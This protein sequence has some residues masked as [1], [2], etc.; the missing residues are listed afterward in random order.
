MTEFVSD[1]AQLR[2]GPRYSL[3]S[4]SST[5]S[6]HGSFQSVDMLNLGPTSRPSSG[7][8]NPHSQRLPLP[9]PEFK[10]PSYGYSYGSNPSPTSHVQSGYGDFSGH[11][12]SRATTPGM[13]AHLPSISLHSQKRAY[14]Q[15]RKDPS[16]DA[17]RE[18]KVK[19][20][21]VPPW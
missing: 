21:S 11:P 6:Y 8:D 5:P 12:G 18:R 13:S 19:V 1:S 15:R 17:C 3:S 7:P 14:R 9:P 4:S 2:C 10:S 16:C 20:G